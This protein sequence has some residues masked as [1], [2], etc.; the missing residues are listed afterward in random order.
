M[1]EEPRLGEGILRPEWTAVSDG[2]LEG[3]TRLRFQMTE[4]SHRRGIEA[5][6]EIG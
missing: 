3:Q 6:A 4:A 2:V 1:H 5:R